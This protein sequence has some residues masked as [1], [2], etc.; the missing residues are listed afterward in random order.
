MTDTVGSTVFFLLLH[1]ARTYIVPLLKSMSL[2]TCLTTAGSSRQR[3]R[4]L[5]AHPPL[6]ERGKHGDRNVYLESEPD[7][8]R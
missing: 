3:D 6:A 8:A 7:S 1:V 4:V 2:T 5:Y